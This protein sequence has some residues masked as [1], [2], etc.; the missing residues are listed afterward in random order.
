[1]TFSFHHLKV[2]YPFG[3]KWTTA[4]V[5]VRA[6]KRVLSHW[7][8][9]M[10]A[11]GGWNALFWCNHDQPRIVSRMG[12]TGAF[13]QASAKTLATLM[14]LLQG[15]PY[16]YQG[17]ELGMANPGYASIADYRDVESLNAYAAMRRAGTPE[18]EVLAVLAAMSRDNGRSPM[19]WD[20]TVHAGFSSGR[21][22]IP[23]A[24]DHEVVNAENELADPHSVYWHYRTLARLRRTEPL[25]TSGAFE[26]L[27]PDDDRVFAYLRRGADATLLVVC[28]ITANSYPFA[29]PDE[30]ADRLAT[31]TLVVTSVP[32][33][34]V[35]DG[36]AGY[37]PLRPWDG[38]V[39][40]FP[41]PEHPQES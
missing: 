34:L 18:P 24:A 31:A 29:V 15:T 30:L 21:P 1:M 13:R 37:L 9:G 4:P 41:L 35:G 17:E 10:A 38:L 39:L 36:G 23:V 14:H 7:Q 33:P 2:D 11:G 26:L 5:D 22:W 12:D 28:N 6:L 19:Q 20:A 3:E 16:I 40:R 8:T 32:E 27:A 25:V